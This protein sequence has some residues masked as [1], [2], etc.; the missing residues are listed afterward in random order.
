M[1]FNANPSS[2]KGRCEHTHA[3]ECRKRS[4]AAKIATEGAHIG[5]VRSDRARRTDT[6]ARPIAVL[7]WL[8][9]AALDLAGR[10]RERPDRTLRARGRIVVALK[11]ADG[12]LR[13]GREARAGREG[14]GRTRLARQ[15]AGG[16]RKRPGRARR[17][18][19]GTGGRSE[20]SGL[21]QCARNRAETRRLGSHRARRAAARRGRVRVGPGRAENARGL[22][23]RRL[24]RATLARDARR[25]AGRRAKCLTA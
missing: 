22:V 5:L 6:L 4:G 10:G 23:G 25:Q 21:A 15:R 3:D 9:E 14:A 7:P 18:C 20:R 11:R 24:V 19:V 1:S 17:A 16:R 2:G 12:A 8:A 13:T